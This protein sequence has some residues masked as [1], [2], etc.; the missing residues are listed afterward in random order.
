MSV[1]RRPLRKRPQAALRSAR[2][3]PARKSWRKEA[4]REECQSIS[5]KSSVGA[6]FLT[7]SVRCRI[8]DIAQQNRLSADHAECAPRAPE[9]IEKIISPLTLSVVGAG[10]LNLSCLRCSSESWQRTNRGG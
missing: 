3:L 10:S 7:G 8:A 1:G 4:E 2:L 9:L 5:S 6:K